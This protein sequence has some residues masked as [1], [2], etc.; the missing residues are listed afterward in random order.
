VSSTKDKTSFGAL[1]EM[2]QWEPVTIDKTGRAVDVILSMQNVEAH[3]AMQREIL[4]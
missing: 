1:L 3:E 4:Q 2:A